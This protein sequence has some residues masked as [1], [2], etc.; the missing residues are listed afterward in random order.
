MTR[1]YVNWASQEEALVLLKSA[2]VASIPAARASPIAPIFG[3]C[4]GGDGSLRVWALEG[5]KEEILKYVAAD[6]TACTCLAF[7]SR[8][9]VLAVGFGDGAIRIFDVSAAN[10]YLDAI[11]LWQP[12]PQ[13]VRYP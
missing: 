3:S 6:A 8:E 11:L 13:P 12:S 5:S 1:R 4:G 2:H 9:H 7:S 10:K